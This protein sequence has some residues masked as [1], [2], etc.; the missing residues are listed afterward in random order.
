[1]EDMPL[2]LEIYE[3]L[4]K[5]IKDGEYPE[6]TALP[7]ERALCQ[8]YHVS[9]STI[10]AALEEL[11]QNG[12]IIKSHGNGNFVKPKM[13]EQKM[14]KFHSFADSLKCQHHRITNLILSCELIDTDKYLSSLTGMDAIG[15]TR[16]FKLTRLRS[17]DSA[18]LMIE[19]DYLAQSRFYNIDVEELYDGSLYSYLDKHFHPVISGADESLTPLLPNNKERTWLQ[20]PA[21]IPCMLCERFCYEKGNLIL[22]HHT[23]VR[24]DRFKFKTAYYTDV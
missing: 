3:D 24:G 14:T 21:H 10:R 15:K 2:Y 11:C 22:I 13:F 9:R 16:W 17:T 12:Y 6:N 18:P 19:T 8:M 7:S 4:Q 20:I 5:K 23:I 1:M